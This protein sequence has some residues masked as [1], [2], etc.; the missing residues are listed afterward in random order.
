ML[1]DFDFVD[2]NCLL[3][4]SWVELCYSLLLPSNA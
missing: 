2:D 3:N 1:H 4:T